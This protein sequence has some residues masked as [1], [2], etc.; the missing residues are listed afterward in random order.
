[1][2]RLGLNDFGAGEVCGGEIELMK[3]LFHQLL[4]V[5]DS[6]LFVENVWRINILAGRKI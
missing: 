1:M 6:T 3:D 2:N 5:I 4:P